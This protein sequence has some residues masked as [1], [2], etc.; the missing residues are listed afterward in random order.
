[1]T[2]ARVVVGSEP[3]SWGP[4]RS[5]RPLAPLGLKLSNSLL[6]LDDEAPFLGPGGVW[7]RPGEASP[8][9]SSQ[10]VE[11]G[12]PGERPGPFF[13][14]FMDFVSPPTEYCYFHG[15]TASR[16]PEKRPPECSQARGGVHQKHG[17]FTTP[18]NI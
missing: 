14:V 10:G 6:D 3:G 4:F 18:Q 1:M 7:G 13:L 9:G 12:T 15:F 2:R 16:G 11:K 8:G 5:L 17:V